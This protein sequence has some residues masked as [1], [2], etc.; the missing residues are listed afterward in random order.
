MSAQVITFLDSF[1]GPLDVW[2][3]T[4]IGVI[5]VWQANAGAQEPDE[6]RSR[7]AKGRGRSRER[8]IAEIYAVFGLRVVGANS[9]AGHGGYL[10]S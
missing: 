8:T 9:W 1:F 4:G 10:P 3:I 7:H 5:R 2:A 6:L